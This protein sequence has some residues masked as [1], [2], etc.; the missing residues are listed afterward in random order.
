MLAPPMCSVTICHDAPGRAR[1]CS[2]AFMHKGLRSDCG[3]DMRLADMV[4][5]VKKPVRA[6]LLCAP[7]LR[8]KNGG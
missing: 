5:T 4:T 1:G 8:S 2:L 6:C 3:V 7:D